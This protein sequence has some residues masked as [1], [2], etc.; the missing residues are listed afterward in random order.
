MDTQTILII[1]V[2]LTGFAVLLQAC[3]LFG[4]F[5]SLRQAAKSVLQ[6]TEDLKATVVPMVHT[7]R[8]LVERITPQVITISTGLSELTESL[9]K[10]SSDVRVSVGEILARINRQTERMDRML[11]LGLDSVVRTGGVIE[12]TVAAP[13]RQ[14]NGVFAAA[15]AIVETYRSVVPRRQPIH[16]I[17]SEDSDRIEHVEFI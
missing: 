14:V 8:E 5:L 12:A 1:F 9:H 7:T 13:L 2:G 3:V 11:T 4:I 17:P 6:A 16:P 15:K 10:D